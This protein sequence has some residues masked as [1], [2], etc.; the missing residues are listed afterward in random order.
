M[1]K[2]PYLMQLNTQ[3]QAAVLH[4]QGP[5]AVIAGAGSGKTRM[6][7][8][9]IA[10]LIVDIGISPERVLAV[11]FTNKATNEMRERVV[12]M[13]G[14]QAEKAQISTYHSLCAKILRSEIGHFGYPTHFNIIDGADQK[15]ILDTIYKMH[16]ASAKQFTHSSMLDYISRNKVLN[17]SPSQK[18]SEARK[19]YEKLEAAVYRDYQQELERVKALDFDDLIIF[20]H[21]LFKENPNARARW[22]QK[23]DYV[24]VD[25]FQDTSYTQYEIL[26]TLASRGNITIVGDPDQTIYTWRWADVDLINNFQK[27]FKGA[28]IIKLEQNYRSTQLILNH[29]NKLIKHNRMRIDKNLYTNND[30]GEGIEFF[31][32]F[33]DEAEARWIVQKIYELKKN[34]TQLKD[35][36]I[37]Y[38]ANYISQSI[39]RAL[40]RGNVNYVV[41]G[42]TRFYQR[43]EIKDAISYLKIISNGDEVSV[44]RMINVPP[45]SLGG[46]T[47]AKLVEFAKKVG[48]PLLSALTDHFQD[49]PL[50]IK[51]RN[52]LATFINLINKYRVALKTN[53]IAKVLRSFLI[54]INYLD[55][56][57]APEDKSRLENI[58]ELIR[59]I[60]VWQKEHQDK[61]L[62]DYLEEIVLYIDYENIS[63]T[64]DFVSL[65]TAH[66]AKGL[67]FKNVFIAGFSESVFPSARAIDEGGEAALE[68][69][70]RLAYVA[71]TRAMKK[72]FIS[73]SRGYSIDYKSQKRPSRFLKEMGINTSRFTKSFIA[74]NL[75]SEAINLANE[76]IVAGDRV[77]H[78]IFGEGTVINVNNELIDIN[79]RKPY[80]VK[81]LMKNH[82]SIE[83]IGS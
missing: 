40:I 71:L 23:F 70:R 8:S 68:E 81:T 45:R 41:F 67:E 36:A 38:R 5:L 57:K 22:S 59:S 79:F 37:I 77:S 51:Q 30:Q 50:Q 66:A 72:V 11:T 48:K 42:G 2:K 21:K 44:L 60:D 82:K 53:P 27:Y 52:E 29:A 54:E 28:K 14:S 7:T 6:L 25:E 20:V 61:Q 69:E 33:S 74:E 17:I 12:E 43:K 46:T 15:Q 10:Y 16:G 47:V 26:E 24:L 9:K 39:E 65:M 4:V 32:A 76:N 80:G 55:L 63:R 83:R 18:M 75:D 19:D 62:A 35:I 3:Q 34:K 49:L 31:S 13:I 73:S 64:N 56:W 58:N 1:S 78:I